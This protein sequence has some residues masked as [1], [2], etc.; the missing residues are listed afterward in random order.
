[1]TA[2]ALNG[3]PRRMSLYLS[4][5]YPVPQRMALAVLVYM[6]IAAFAGHI[7]NAPVDLVSP[8]TAV[9]VGSIFAMFLIV[10]LMDE[11]KDKDIDR[12]LFRDRPL[13]SGR[14]HESDIVISLVAAI[15]L[16]LFA[17]L[18]AGSALWPA[19]AVLAYALLMFRH[20]F[21]PRIL[22]NSLLLTFA[23]HSPLFLVVVFYAFA[24]F[25]AESGSPLSGLHWNLIALFAVMLWLPTLAWEVARKIRPPGEEDGYETY[26]GMFGRRGA[27][28]ICANLQVLALAIGAVLHL[29]LS[30]SDGYM[31]ILAA[32]FCA[33]AICHVLFLINPGRYAAA[34][35]P[36]AEAYIFAVLLAQ[37]AGFAD[38]IRW[39]VVA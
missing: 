30:L 29:G 3:F 27:V 8:A 23:T 21:I 16:Y 13:P 22:E 37:V 32:G 10:R 35:R 34:L 38:A 2:Q 25:A 11:L 19:L 28:L 4:E 24:V 31:A 15:G 33:V 7:H 14:V 36:A 17:N 6:A 20:F 9:A 12:A 5:M 26:S 1:M 18:W 39:G